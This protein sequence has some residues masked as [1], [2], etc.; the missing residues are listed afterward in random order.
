MAAEILIRI[1]ESEIVPELFPN[2]SI[3]N[4]A[5]NDDDN[6][7]GNTVETQNSG[8]LPAVLVDN[9]SWPLAVSQRTDSADN[10]QIETLNT[11]V[12]Q[13]TDVEALIEAGGRNKRSSIINQQSLALRTKATSRILVD[14]TNGVTTKVDT[15]GA[16]AASSLPGTTGTRKLVTRADLLAAL[17]ILDDQDVPRD[18][19][20]Q[21]VWVVPARYYSTLTNIDEFI[22]AD[23]LGTQNGPLVTGQIGTL[24]GVKVVMRS[25]VI[26]VTASGDV[27]AEEA[28]TAATDGHGSILYHP[29]FVRKA[30]GA[31]RVR[32]NEDQAEWGGTIMGSELRFGG[33]PYRA[34][35]KGVVI[36]KEVAGA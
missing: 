5:I 3:V 35:K 36:I 21:P 27:K 32:I 28:A 18:E 20:N 12:T 4:F 8:T 16:A 31:F 6:V 11:A 7:R 33:N 14:W 34:D 13:L 19:M 23:K 29:L 22:S 10:Y 1:F 15:T 24:Y 2:N 30:Q 26:R 25:L 9:T 17:E